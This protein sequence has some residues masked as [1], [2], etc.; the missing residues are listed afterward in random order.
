VYNVYV[1][2]AGKDYGQ[3]QKRLFFVARYGQLSGKRA[4][5]RMV[6]C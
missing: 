4:K 2:L 3:M 1:I 6:C 5:K